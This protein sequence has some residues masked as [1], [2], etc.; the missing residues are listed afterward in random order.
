VPTVPIQN[1]V[2]AIGD[3]KPDGTGG[4]NFSH[5]GVAIPGIDALFKQAND[6][7][8]LEKRLAL[9]RQMEIKLLQDMPV[10]SLTNTAFVI[11]RNPKMDIGFKVT[12]GYGYWRLT[13][14]V[15]A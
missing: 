13:D 10:I 4:N 5:Y 7:P 2:L 12:S 1:E 14:A 8:D 15:V 9:C 3:C 6:E 11:I